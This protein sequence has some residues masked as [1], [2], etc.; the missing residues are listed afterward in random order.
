MGG[1]AQR[2][3]LLGTSGC[4]S[5]TL[6]QDTETPVAGCGDSGGW[7]ARVRSWQVVS[8]GFKCVH[9]FYSHSFFEEW[10]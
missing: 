7:S 3:V 8:S 6:K 1:S 4:L 10:T 5:T 9:A 2:A